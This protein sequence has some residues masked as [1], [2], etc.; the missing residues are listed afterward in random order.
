MPKRPPFD[1]ALLERLPGVLAIP[2]HQFAAT[3]LPELRLHRLCDAVEI[4]TRFATVLAV[5]E[6]RLPDDPSKLPE[7]LVKALGPTIQ[8]PTFARWLGMV[9]D[10]ADFLAHDRANPMV[11]PGLP[12]FIGDVLLKA[13][14]AGNRYLDGSILELR[15]TLAHGGAMSAPMAEY[16][17]R[18]DPTGLPRGVR[19]SVP[20]TAEAEVEEAAADQAEPPP[21]AIAFRGWEAV[22]GDMATGLADLLAGSRVCSF[23]G[24]AAALLMGLELSGAVE[25]LS[26]DRRLALRQRQLQGHVLLLCEGR[27]LDLWPLCDHG[28]ARLSSLRGPL[29]SDADAPLLYYRG[30]PQRLLYAAFGATP[31]VSERGDAV[32]DFEALFRPAGPR[33]V[34]T[35]TA[36]DFTEELRRDSQQ[37]VGRAVELKHVK[38]A[39][40]QTT[41]GVLWL[42]GTGGIGK[43][44]LAARVV[45]NLGNDPRRWCCIPWRFRVS[46]TDRSNPNAFLRHA[47]TSLA[48]WP[49]LGRS[50]VRPDI[51]SNKLLAQLDELLRTAGQLQPASKDGEPPRVLFMLD[52]MD[53]AARLSP[54]LVE[55]PFRLPHPNVVWL[56]TGRPEATTQKAFAPDRCTHLFPGGL[57]PMGAGDV[58]ELLYQELGEQKYRLL[59][60]DT[61]DESDKL[62]NALVVAIVEKSEGLPLYVHFLV[63]D[64]LTGEFALDRSLID[65]LPRGLGAYYDDLLGR[66]GVGAVQALLT[67]LVASVVWARGPV[68]E[69]MLLELMFRRKLL[70]RREDGQARERLQQGMQA[71]GSMLRQAPLPEGRFG[72]EPYHLTFRNHFRRDETGRIADQNDLA[73]DEFCELTL[74]WAGLPPHAAARLYVL[75]HGP[76]HLL[77]EQRWEELYALARDEAFLRAQA[78]ELPAEPEAALR[79]LQ[80]ALTAAAQRDDA[81]GMVEFLVRHAEQA[82]ALQSQSPLAA[83]RNGNL[84]RALH[85]ADLTDGEC[86]VVHRL[87]LAWELLDRDRTAEARQVLDQLTGRQSPR[88]PEE[89]GSPAA[90]CL[91]R[92]SRS[93]PATVTELARRLLVHGELVRLGEALIGQGL[94]TLVESLIGGETDRTTRLQLLQ[95]IAAA[96]AGAGQAEAAR[97][98]FAQALLAAGA[99]DNSHERSEALGAISVAQVQAG[100]LQEALRTAD[101][102]E[103]ASHRSQAL[104]A[105]AAAQ[106]QA[107]QPQEALRTADAIED[108][109]HRSAAVRAIAASVARPGRA[110]GARLTFAQ[111][112]LAADAIEDARHR[113]AALEAIAAAQAQA[114]QPQEALRTADAIANAY[115]R[116]GALRAVAVAQAQAGQVEAARPTLAQALQAAGAIEDARARSGALRDIAVAQAQAGQPQEACLT[117][118]QAIHVAARIGDAE[119]Q[120]ES[121]RA[122]AAAQAQTGQAEAA[123][124][125]FEQ[126][127]QAAGAIGEARRQS[128]AL[129]AIAAAQAQAG[130][131]EGAQEMLRAAMHELEAASDERQRVELRERIAY[132]QVSIDAPHQA[133]ATARLILVEREKHLPAIMESFLQAKDRTA[134]KELLIPCA[135]HLESAWAVCGHI[136]R[137][138]PEQ[139]TAIAQVAV[140]FTSTSG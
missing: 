82:Q 48:R 29:E 32:A 4:L 88:L 87:L 131:A 125:T 102:I 20:M 16:L 119:E 50:D 129:Q 66:I 25:E 65:R 49:V 86:A 58:R 38:D 13:A 134:F 14:P 1:A 51:D 35:E 40:K 72:Y 89:F 93:F 100:Q 31:P 99:L 75:R 36:R 2:L 18:G 132:L 27:W 37:L 101:A 112:L 120:S 85:L 54:D 46:D 21:A 22:L 121:L 33:D 56:C 70:R 114:G 24:T 3:E 79:T 128:E 78:E 113:S 130:Q 34:R 77:E 15:N 60:E 110:E 108:A 115:H 109:S 105:V 47:I 133:M 11:L 19:P 43:S 136:A 68:A 23:D 103:D 57:P 17:L 91:A 59:A 74:D 63:E 98:T 30:E 45:V 64:L 126:A 140:R 135:A 81:A 111:A 95:A 62:T 97:L 55:W 106:A 28:K 90:V 96:Q 71:V 26:A 6:A 139:V 67:P 39:L 52:G 76:A 44:F 94:L 41:S 53:E 123:R 42:S 73:R 107:G 7:P 116:S 117:F 124:L 5:A 92:I 138:Y 122:I 69:E 137:A 12:R 9:S 104:G 118:A 8:M 80:A 83:L 127:R 61:R 84:E 10:L